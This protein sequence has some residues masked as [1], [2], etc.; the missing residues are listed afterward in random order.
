MLAFDKDTQK[1]IFKV[2]EERA[3]GKAVAEMDARIASVLA[4]HP[5]FDVFWPRGEMMAAIPQEINGTIVNPFVHTV[6]H[7]IV[8]KQIGDESP[9]FVAETHRRL[10]Q[11]GI[12]E[13]ESLHAIISIF[14]DLYFT[15]VRRGGGQFDHLEYESRLEGISVQNAE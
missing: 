13:H 12:D 15:S 6:L 5:E 11:E 3:Q 10:L 7:A 8:D 2:A 9:E 4:L 1:R 14:A